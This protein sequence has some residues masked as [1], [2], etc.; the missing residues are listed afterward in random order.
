MKRVDYY[1][2]KDWRY[3]GDMNA[4][5][6]GLWIR[7][8]GTYADA[9]EI[10]D[11]DSACGFRGAVLIE[12]HSIYYGHKLAE[13]K[14][15]LRSAL[16][17]VGMKLSDLVGLPRDKRRFELWRALHAYGYRDSDTLDILQLEP[18][19]PLKFESWEARKQ[20]GGDVGGYVMA[21]YLD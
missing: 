10:T 5:H 12:R 8:C 1:G 15:R 4:E 20:T 19:G 21:K 11:L 2:N 17:C 9:V 13:S 3:S 14:R 6:G 7:D 18:D 16:S